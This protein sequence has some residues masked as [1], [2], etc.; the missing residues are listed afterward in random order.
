[1]TRRGKSRCPAEECAAANPI[2]HD[3]S[4]RLIAAGVSANWV[5][6]ARRCRSCGCVYT[7]SI[8]G[9]KIIRGYLDNQVLG[10]GWKPAGR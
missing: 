8:T 1:M 2:Q 9:A 5:K 7:T 3:A 4:E 10:P 6:S